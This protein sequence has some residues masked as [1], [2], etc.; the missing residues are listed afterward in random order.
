ME[1]AILAKISGSGARFCQPASQCPTERLPSS[2]P[3]LAH[4]PQAGLSRDT[5]AGL[6]VPS[7]CGSTVTSL[8]SGTQSQVL[9]CL[10]DKEGQVLPYRQDGRLPN[11]PQ[12]TGC[13]S[14][15][16]LGLGWFIPETYTQRVAGRGSVVTR[17]LA[18]NF[19]PQYDVSTFPCQL[20]P[21]CFLVGPNYLS[22][23]CLQSLFPRG[24]GTGDT[25][26][27]GKVTDCQ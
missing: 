5:L 16:T 9:P 22:S 8:L 13:L 11:S 18:L 12:S 14:I 6:A 24:V 17:A 27:P 4:Y 21:L 1:Q 20:T 3:A 2:G 23:L 15:G 25:K 10:V 26:A 19:F 7:L